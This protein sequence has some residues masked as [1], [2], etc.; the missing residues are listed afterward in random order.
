MPVDLAKLTRTELIVLDVLVHHPNSGPHTIQKY[1]KEHGTMYQIGEVRAAL[2]S[3]LTKRVIETSDREQI[4][5]SKEEI[6]RYS[7]V[8]DYEEYTVQLIRQ[9]DYY[10][11]GILTEALS[12][13]IDSIDDMDFLKALGKKINQKTRR[14]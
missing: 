5:L 14:K 3:L 8:C 11:K 4:K 2:E 10:K 9:S 13:M 12:K 6:I 1:T 7:A